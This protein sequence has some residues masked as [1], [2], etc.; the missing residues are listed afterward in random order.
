MSPG[1]RHAL[2]ADDH[3]RRPYR[4][5]VR[6]EQARQTREDILDALTDLLAERRADD[7]TTR[8][9]AGRA[10]VSAPTVYR[11]F[12]D[13]TALLDGLAERVDRLAVAT[14]GGYAVSGVDELGPRVEWLFAAADDHEEEMRAEALLNAD[15]RRFASG[16]QRHSTQMLAVVRDGLPELSERQ[17][18]QLTGVLRCLGSAQAWLRMR[19]EFGVSGA[20]AGPVMRWAVDTLLAAARNGELPPCD[21]APPAGGG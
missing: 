9:I 7:I 14:Q 13:R 15:P 3:G 17:A 18:V 20:E 16:T 1:S 6:E 12:P 2:S 19:E 11:Y 5:P 4:S 10:G 8:E 21:P